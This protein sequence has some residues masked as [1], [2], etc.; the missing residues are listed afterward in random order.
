MSVA[1]GVVTEGLLGDN[2]GVATNDVRT[3][4]GEQLPARVA[5]QVLHG[6]YAD[7]WR[8]TDASSAFYARRRRVDGHLHRQVFPD[9]RGDHRRFPGDRD[10]SI[11]QACRSKGVADGPQF[12]DCVYDVLVMGDASYATAAAAVKGELID[13]HAVSFDAD[14]VLD[15]DFVS[16]VAANFA[17]PSYL[18]D[19]ATSRVAGPIFDTPGYSFYALDAPRHHR[20]ELT[21][22]LIAYGAVETDSATQSVDVK[23]DDHAPISV[24]LEG[25]Q[26]A[27][28]TEDAATLARVRS[29]ETAA[30][31]PFTVYRLTALA[32]HIGSSLKIVLAPHGFRGVLGT[33]LGV[34]RAR[35]QLA[36]T[37]ADSFDVSLPFGVGAGSISP[38]PAR[39]HSRPRQRRTITSPW[40][41]SVIWCS[42]STGASLHRSPWCPSPAVSRSRRTGPAVETGFS[43]TC[44]R[45]TTY[46]RSGWRAVRATTPSVCSTA[47]RP[48]AST[49]NLARQSPMDP[50]GTP[51]PPVR[52]TS[53]SGLA[54]R[55][56]PDGHRARDLAFP[57]RGGCAP[58][59][60]WCRSGEALPWAASVASV[61]SHSPPVTTASRSRAQEEARRAPTPSSRFL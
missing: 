56:R 1:P 42:M 52:A 14:G 10:R 25:D 43:P 4:N 60:G 19:P 41:A 37:P 17:F 6:R 55:L 49:I 58:T 11:P 35:V 31:T 9:E 8:V 5:Q 32:E 15:E 44:R 26:A 45:V 46:S 27:T 30:G 24:P 48:S 59:R 13:P 47:P 21:L 22:D 39:A 16:P 33:S 12:D 3:S 50:S 53:S 51:P 20:L 54:R 34:D 38:A 7:S 29:G 2:D 57:R 28:S 23:I 36:T 40:T 61:R 18:D